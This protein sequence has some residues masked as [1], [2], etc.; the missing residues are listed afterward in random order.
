MKISDK[1]PTRS[2][3]KHST[4]GVQRH[5]L[6]D[7]GAVMI[8][9]FKEKLLEAKKGLIVGI[10]NEQSIAWG[11]AKAF[12]RWSRVGRHLPQRQGQEIRRAARARARITDHHTARRPRARPD[13][14]GVR[15][16]CE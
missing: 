2:S 15:M 9:A 13:A 3:A 1:H 10:A 7:E 12:A 8:P 16:H 5:K 4:D 6:K 14:G 11:C